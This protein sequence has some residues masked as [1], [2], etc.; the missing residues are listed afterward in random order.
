M[1]EREKQIELFSKD[2]KLKPFYA[3]IE[4]DSHDQAKL[5]GET[6][7]AESQV[8]SFEKKQQSLAIA[9][10][11]T[12]RRQSSA[13]PEESVDDEKHLDEFPL[14]LTQGKLKLK[15]NQNELQR[16]ARIRR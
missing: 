13:I 3:K 5:A 10:D 11:G 12:Q 14:L 1:K 16:L 6:L 7:G 9:Q 2:L 15:L 8:A 4:K